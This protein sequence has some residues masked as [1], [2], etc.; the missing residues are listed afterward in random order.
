MCIS[1]G[2]CMV[3]EEN[4]SKKTKLIHT[5]VEQTHIYYRDKAK[6]Y[7][8]RTRSI[9][10]TSS[11][12]KFLK[13]VPQSEQMV[14]LDLGCGSG[15]DVSVFKTHGYI[16]D[17]IDASI[18]MAKQTTHSTHI[19]ALCE[20][21]QELDKINRYAGIWA[22]ASLLHLPSKDLLS[23]FEKINNALI[24]GGI[25]YAS[26]KYGHG[27]HIRGGRFFHDENEDSLRSLISL[28][29][30]LE[31][32]EMWDNR[33]VGIGKSSDERWLNSIIKKQETVISKSVMALVTTP[34]RNLRSS[35]KDNF[36]LGFQTWTEHRKS[37]DQIRRVKITKKRKNETQIN[38]NDSF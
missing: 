31:I 2:I 15:R 12:D 32:L 20:K 35:E 34:S 16:V 36:P 22:S 10:M 6:E 4:I 30:G 1:T 7:C 25:L 17:A 28:V 37:K 3:E 27:E 21:I 26:F 38:L 11:Y 23:T 14:I 19:P 8:E 5:A 13:Y 18:E 9:D 24:S 29:P 33:D